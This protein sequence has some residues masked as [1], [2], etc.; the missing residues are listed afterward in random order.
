M[1]FT[2]NN[3]LKL[4]T[5]SIGQDAFKDFYDY[6]W[7]ARK[8]E[9]Q[10]LLKCKYDFDI[11]NDKNFTRFVDIL[12][13]FVDWALKKDYINTWDK[14][15][16]I[17]FLFPYMY[18][19]EFTPP[20]VIPENFFIEYTVMYSI[21][22]VYKRSMQE[23]LKTDD[24]KNKR[25]EAIISALFQFNF[26]LTSENYTKNIEPLEGA[27]DL[28]LALAKD[29]YQ[30][31]EYWNDKKFQI[32]EKDSTDLKILIQRWTKTKTS[33]PSWKVIKLFMNEELLPD[34]NLINNPF[35]DVTGKVLYLA[36]RRKVFPAYFITNFFDSLLN[37]G[38][39]NQESIE[40]I[41]NGIR[42]FYRH[43][44]VTNEPTFSQEERKNKMFCMLYR[45]LIEDDMGYDFNT[46]TVQCFMRY[47]F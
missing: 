14:Q 30:L 11:I 34:E 21:C 22:Y 41:K 7:Q 43:Y 17:D 26:Y 37:Q 46:E 19:N 5:D 13:D 20:N 1:N 12:N 33:R 25:S 47:L 6:N 39:I 28:F 9:I 3:I 27:F 4:F 8:K 2:T 31:F 18:A 24:F 44:L 29:K 40:M 15:A 32:D 38:F 10:K 36:F 42:L 23:L 45:F 35:T 16:I